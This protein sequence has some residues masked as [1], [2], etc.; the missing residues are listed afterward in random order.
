LAFDVRRRLGNLYFASLR[1]ACALVCVG[2]SLILG[3]HWFG[4]LPDSKP[5]EM[6]ARQSLSEAIAL[7]AAAHIRK[8]Q[9]AD[10]KTTLQTQVDRN[11]D[12]LSIGV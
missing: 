5:I 2:A 7:N 8:Q 6:R 9:W 1:F 10:V 12:L 4:F 3:A 11:P